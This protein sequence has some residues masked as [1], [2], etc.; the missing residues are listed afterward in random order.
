[1]I[2]GAQVKYLKQFLQTRQL[3]LSTVKQMHKDHTK[4]LRMRHALGGSIKVIDAYYLAKLLE[5]NK[6]KTILEIGSF[7][8]FSTHWLLKNSESWNAKVTAL[9]PNIRHR[10]FDS[11]RTILEKLNEQ[12]LPDRLEIITGFLGSWTSSVYWDY[13]HREPKRSREYVDNLL[14]ERVVI[15]K[16][17]DR[18]FDF[19]FIDGDHSYPSVMRD[20]KTC[21]NF[22]KPN[23]LIAF[24]DSMS[25]IGVSKVLTE[26]KVDYLEQAQVYNLGGPPVKIA[27]KLLKGPI[28]IVDGIGVFELV[29]QK[30]VA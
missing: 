2:K 16:T 1:M 9:D 7:L 26:L 20:F 14:K 23:G 5:Q 30:D 3:L 29:Q 6:P 8:G 17:W 18:K 24:H 11:P 13:E 4:W 15:D 22:L 12:Y 25:S 28:R 19:I 27:Q 21:Y 10:I